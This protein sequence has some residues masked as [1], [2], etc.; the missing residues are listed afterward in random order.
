MLQR[1]MEDSNPATALNPFVN[2]AGNSAATLG[3]IDNNYR[4]DNTSSQR[5]REVQVKG[6]GPLFSVGGGEARIA[7]G[8]DLRNEQAVQLQTSGT[9]ARA[10]DMFIVRDDNISRDVFA[11]FAELNVPF[12]SSQNALPWMQRLTLSLAGRADYYAAYGT[13]FNPKLGIVVEPI[14]GFSL[15]ASYGKSF[16]AP[17]VGMI[18][19]KFGFVGSQNSSG[20]YTY[21]FPADS[22]RAGETISIG[23][24]AGTEA[25]TYNVYNSGGGNPDLKPEKATTWSLG[26]DIAPPQVPGLRLSVGYYNVLYQNT[27]YKATMNDV[28]YKPGFEYLLTVSPTIGQ[29]VSNAYMDA[30][31]AA[32][33]AESPPEM[34]LATYTVWDVIFRSYAVNIGSR[35]FEGL[36]FDGAYDFE[37]NFGRFSVAG[38]ANLKLVDTQKVLPTDPYVSRLGSDQAVKWKGRGSLNW[39]YGPANVNLAMNY[40]GSYKLATGVRY[41]DGTTVQKVKAW[42]TFDLGVRYSLDQLIKGFSIQGRVV[43]L[44][45]KDPPWVDSGAGYSSSN[46]NAYGRMFE[47]TVRAAF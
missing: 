37:T 23:N 31:V 26:L 14:A 12:I 21:T 41:S 19:H 30:A 33:Y 8:V 3:S 16:V 38:N 28:F 36:D 11:G 10:A 43:N 44:F 18:T 27:I 29:G 15:H 24:T 42:T 32:E 17:N 25:A 47:V 45:D 35:K 13:R 22:P 46:S 40:V 9:P 6:D 2:A 7:V 4:R 1:A 5:L 20:F 39:A 34:D